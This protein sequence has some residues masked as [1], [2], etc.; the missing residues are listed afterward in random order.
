MSCKINF[1]CLL[2]LSNIWFRSTFRPTSGACGFNPSQ[3]YVTWV[4]HPK[5]AKAINKTTTYF[6]PPINHKIVFSNFVMFRHFPDLP[7]PIFLVI[8]PL[9][10]TGCLYPTISYSSWFMWWHAKLCPYQWYKNSLYPTISYPI[11]NSH[12][13]MTY[14]ILCP[15]LG[16]S[17]N[18]VPLNPV[19]YHHFLKKNSHI[20]LGAHPF[21]RNPYG[22]C[23]K[24]GLP[25]NHPS[26]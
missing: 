1:H 25:P 22:S 20:F 11:S 7:S 19:V 21:Q 12:L 15:T 6:K 18:R 2:C 13:F 14:P 4:H 3:K 23:L 16:L 5:Y 8:L 26:F 10:F 24:W 9:K 17:E